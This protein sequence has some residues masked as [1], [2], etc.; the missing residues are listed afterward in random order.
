MENYYN[1]CCW[2]VSRIDRPISRVHHNHH[3]RALPYFLGSTNK[4]VRND[5]LCI[6]NAN[7]VPDLDSLSSSFTT[8]SLF[9]NYVTF[10]YG[11]QEHRVSM[12]TL[13]K[14]SLNTRD[15]WLFHFHERPSLPSIYLKIMSLNCMWVLT[16]IQRIIRKI[17]G[18]IKIK[19]SCQYEGRTVYSRR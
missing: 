7:Y 18:T 9:N 1:R 17:K 4:I 3:I 6:V 8:R 15:A 19:N 2:Y 11:L 10:F 12:E 13:A 16:I 14:R 5:R